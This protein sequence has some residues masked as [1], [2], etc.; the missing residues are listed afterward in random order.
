M[1]ESTSGQ[2]GRTFELHALRLSFRALDPIHFPRGKA[3]NMLRGALG[4]TFRAIACMADCPGAKLCDFRRECAYARMFE[5]S[6]SDVGPSGLRDWPRP[7]VF[8]AARLDGKTIRPGESFEFDLNIFEVRDPGPACLLLALAELAREG[9]GP[10][11]GRAEL[12]SVWQLDG[13]GQPRDLICNSSNF[14]LPWRPLRLD[15]S[16]TSE[17]VDRVRVRFLTPTELKSSNVVAAKPEFAILFGRIRDRVSTLCSLYGSGPLEI[18]FKSMGERAALVRMTACEI[19][20]IDVSRQSS[21]TGQ[22]HNL[23]GFVGWAEYQ[24]ELD[25]FL[26]FLRAAKWTGV[27]RHCVWGNGEIELDVYA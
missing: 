15:L 7:F 18:D 27:G 9:L 5:P 24:G 26:P 21:R 25:E 4:S 10:G 3:G 12:Q 23:G 17:H 1:D 2:P 11:R 16:R 8:R 6:Q 14:A 20:R 19:N 22:T 13:G